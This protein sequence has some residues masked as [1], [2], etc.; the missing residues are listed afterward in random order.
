MIHP[1]SAWEEY[2]APMARAAA[3]ER[4]RGDSAFAEGIEQDI[5]RERHA[6]DLFW[7]YASF[8]ARR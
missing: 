1:R 5:A 4:A 3:E 7:D 2:H 8:V 6:I